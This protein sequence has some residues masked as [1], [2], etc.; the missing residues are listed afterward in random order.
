[1]CWKM[2]FTSHLVSMISRINTGKGI[3]FNKA[4]MSL[5]AREMKPSLTVALPF[6][7]CITVRGRTH[8]HLH[9]CVS[10]RGGC[11]SV[12]VWVSSVSLR[13]QVGVATCLFLPCMC[14]WPK[15]RRGCLYGI[16]RT[17][18]HGPLSLC[19]VYVCCAGH[20]GES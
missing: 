4:Y 2:L 11:V 14:K 15:D 12:S 5:R 17:E 3:L 18:C 1:M 16:S 9:K 10:L 13:V 6:Y 19:S 20:R 7:S 8:V